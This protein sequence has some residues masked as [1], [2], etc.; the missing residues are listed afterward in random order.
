M[1]QRE[2]YERMLAGEAGAEEPGCH[3]VRR[4]LITAEDRPRMKYGNGT[5]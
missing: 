1:E 5:S 4:M 3:I 2:E